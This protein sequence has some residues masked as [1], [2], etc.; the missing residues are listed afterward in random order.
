MPNFVC[1]CAV[2]LT[3]G[4]LLAHLTLSPLFKSLAEPGPR[5][6]SGKAQECQNWSQPAAEASAKAL[7]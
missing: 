4:A 5:S 7:I 6:S 3:L 2:P 1:V